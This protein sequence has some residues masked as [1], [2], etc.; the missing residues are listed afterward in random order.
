MNKVIYIKSTIVVLTTS[1]AAAVVGSTSSLAGRSSGRRFGTGVIP[2]D[3]VAK[4]GRIRSAPSENK[5]CQ[6]LSGIRANRCIGPQL[7]HVGVHI[8]GIETLPWID[9]GH[10]CRRSC[11]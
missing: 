1:V 7:G 2:P 8:E 11:D 4:L 3:G 5:Q 10:V 6:Y 9:P